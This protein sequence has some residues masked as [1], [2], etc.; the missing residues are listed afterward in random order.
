MI[1]NSIKKILELLDIIERR[2]LKYLL[3]LVTLTSLIDVA[4]IASIMPFIGLLMDPGIIQENFFLKFLYFY[5]SKFGLDS[6]HKFLFMI[7]IF[8]FFLLVASNLLKALTTYYQ[9]KFARMRE[10]SIGSKLIKKYL[11]QPYEWFINH[12][13][14]NFSTS[15]ISSVQIVIGQAILPMVQLISHSILAISIFSML[16]F[17]NMK[18]SLIICML[19]GISYLIIFKNVKN[20]LNIFGNLRL[21]NNKKRFKAISEAFGAIKEIK[22][23]GTEKNF[24]E[25]YSKP[26]EKFASC[27]AKTLFLTQL[28]R[29]LI[30]IVAF[31]TLIMITLFLM[32]KLNVISTIIPYI[33][34]FA[35]AGY[36]IL[37]SLQIIYASIANLK[38]VQPELNSLY[39]DITE[40]TKDT[41]SADFEKINFRNKISLENVSYKYPNS[42]KNILKNI[43]IELPKRSSTGIVGKTGSGKTTLVDIILGLLSVSEGSLKVDD[44]VIS[45]YNVGSWQKL[46][47]YVPQNIYLADNTISANIAFNDRDP[48][49]IDMTKVEKVAKVAMLHDFIIEL[50][51]QYKTSVG[52]RGIKLSGGQR[53]RIG[54]ARALYYEPK[55]LILDEA[56]S[57]LDNF[58]EAKVMKSIYNIS[59][60]ITVIIIAHRLNT[61]KKCD[62]VLSIENGIITSSNNL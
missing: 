39:N 18:L 8:V 15:I 62:V 23:A 60:D 17:V 43:N 32:L 9:I 7:G 36:R 52:E 10:Y 19:F 53:Q 25:R 11:N 44:T 13:S 61:L 6:E 27:G 21:E 55:V 4:S 30:E 54:I 5:S 35:F 34:L 1:Y 56:T 49:K 59:E 24:L 42:S 51:D 50:P 16:L 28:P 45:K 22:L 14:S 37:P 20:L 41:L 3:V 33:A 58:T 57:A 26:T 38:N 31:G 46:I 40:N 47:G 2:N 48:S 12:H 29:Y